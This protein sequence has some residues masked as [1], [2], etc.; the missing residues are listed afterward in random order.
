MCCEIH[1]RTHQS[2][3]RCAHQ[4]VVEARGCAQQQ[5]Q[6]EADGVAADLAALLSLGAQRQRGVA[7]L[8]K[9]SKIDIKLG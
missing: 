5:S 1:S 6:Q 3:Q 8:Q 9:F 2:L 7:S 4:E